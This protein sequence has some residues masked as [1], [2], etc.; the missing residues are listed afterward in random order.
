[1][2][3]SQ[4]RARRLAMTPEELDEFLAAERVCRIATL[5][6]DGSPHVSPLWFAW[7]GECLWLS[8]AV[9]TQR[10]VNVGRDSRVSVVID[11]GRDYVQLQGVEILGRAEIVGEVPRTDAPNAELDAPERLFA[12]KY[13]NGQV[14][15]DGRH[16][17]VRVIPDKI[18][19]WDNR[20]L[21]PPPST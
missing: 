8:S 13:A 11:S 14:S 4:R 2:P 18:V 21:A 5:G 17:W 7:D 16:A 10:W 6:Q 19:S 9:G 12:D 15:H 1:M 3:R 20:K